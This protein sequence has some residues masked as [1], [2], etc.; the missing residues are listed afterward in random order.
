MIHSP[1]S[2]LC[3]RSGSRLGEASGEA[4]AGRAGE[5]GQANRVTR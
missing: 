1:A 3:G 2:R 5:M 4:R